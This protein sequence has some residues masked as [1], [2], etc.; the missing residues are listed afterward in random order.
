LGGRERTEEPAED[1]GCVKSVGGTVRC[2][3]VALKANNAYPPVEKYVLASS[4]WC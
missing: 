4:G 2:E 3:E 1:A